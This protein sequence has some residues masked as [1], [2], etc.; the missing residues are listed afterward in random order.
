MDSY[1]Y[2]KP[3]LFPESKFSDTDRVVAAAILGVIVFGGLVVVVLVAFAVLS[4]KL[5]STSQSKVWAF[6]DIVVARVDEDGESKFLRS[7]R[8]M[9]GAVFTFLILGGCAVAIAVFSLQLVW[10]NATVTSS[11]GIGLISPYQESAVF[12]MRTR[13]SLTFYGT[14]AG[15]FVGPDGTSCTG[16]FSVTGFASTGGAPTCTAVDATTC[17]L[18]W[19]CESGCDITSSSGR[20]SYTPTGIRTYKAVAVDIQVAARGAEFSQE[21]YAGAAG[22]TLVPETPSN[23]FFL[24][25][26]SPSASSFVADIYQ[27]VTYDTRDQSVVVGY[28]VLPVSTTAIGPSGPLASIPIPS[29]GVPG[30]EVVFSKTKQHTLTRVTRR[31]TTLDFVAGLGGLIS[32][33]ISVGSVGLIVIEASQKKLGLLSDSGKGKVEPTTE[34]S[35]SSWSGEEM[36]SS[37]SAL[38]DDA[39]S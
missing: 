5:S 37:N 29:P 7:R 9:L 19:T 1:V 34:P 38:F 26:S 6:V 20:V 8:N 12:D 4:K 36:M 18:V 28:A 16:S 35:L 3:F 39:Q 13:A 21:G 11:T 25:S 24:P 17:T 33:I 2:G 27:H 32:A 23:W 10:D 14:D 31:L 30:V 22:M 15:T